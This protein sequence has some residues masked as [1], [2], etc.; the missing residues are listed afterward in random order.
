MSKKRKRNYYRNKRIN[1][2]KLNNKNNNERN[3]TQSN[4]PQNIKNIFELVIP[5]IPY[6]SIILSKDF[7]FYIFDFKKYLIVFCLFIYALFLYK[8]IKKQTKIITYISFILFLPAIFI[9]LLYNPYPQHTPVTICIY[10][11][12]NGY[13]TDNVNVEKL[14]TQFMNNL[15]KENDNLFANENPALKY[16]YCYPNYFSFPTTYAKTLTKKMII[17]KTTENIKNIITIILF[18]DNDNIEECIYKLN[19]N[20]FDKSSHDYRIEESNI[21]QILNNII[22]NEPDKDEKINCLT[23]I[24]LL[25]INMRSYKNMNRKFKDLYLEQIIN[26]LDNLKNYYTFMIKDIDYLKTAF[27]LVEADQTT[28]K[29]EQCC[30]LIDALSFYPYYPYLNEKDFYNAYQK[31]VYSKWT[32]E[33]TLLEEPL[34]SKLP[35]L[36]HENEIEDRIKLVDRINDKILDQYNNPFFKLE[37]IEFFKAIKKSNSIFVD[38]EYFPQVEEIINSIDEENYPEFK[39][40]ILFRK[41]SLYLN[42]LIMYG[43]EDGLDENDD[44][45]KELSE[46]IEDIYNNK[47]IKYIMKSLPI[48]E[49]I[50]GKKNSQN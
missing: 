2:K 13:Y 19:P 16:N 50:S 42:L 20:A 34:L 6:L 32:L 35:I 31:H 14:K 8:F 21:Q 22:L 12:I 33:K 28:E 37:K 46:K 11:N 25:D 5:L 45:Y 41:F 40:F 44:L 15:N 1:H 30:K 18:L 38:R 3:K 7:G 48:D 36:I 24:L 43:V 9:L 29:Y 47:E 23:K 10:D 49:I 27:L 39:T 26:H 4:T 17:K